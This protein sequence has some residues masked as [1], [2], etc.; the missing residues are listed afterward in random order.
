MAHS[1]TNP[2]TN[3]LFDV[4]QILPEHE[5]MEEEQLLAKG[6]PPRVEE[7]L[8]R[9]VEE[10]VQQEQPRVQAWVEQEKWVQVFWGEQQRRV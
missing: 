8:V 1:R 10:V 2:Q 4:N 6:P 7:L 9:E 3:I 5:P